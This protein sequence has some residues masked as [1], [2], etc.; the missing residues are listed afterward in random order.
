[1]SDNYQPRN[2]YAPNYGAR[3][4]GNYGAAPY[5]QA[6]YAPSSAPAAPSAPAS[7]YPGGYN[8]APTTPLTVTTRKAPR[9]GAG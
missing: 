9:V 3:P 6:P 5:G 8:M 2:P 7:G 4:A 1:M